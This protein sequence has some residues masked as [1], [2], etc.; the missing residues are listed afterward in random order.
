[1]F[2]SGS[3]SVR[4]FVETDISH[5]AFILILSGISW[6]NDVL[7]GHALTKNFVIFVATG[8]VERVLGMLASRETTGQAARLRS[9]ISSVTVVDDA[10]DI[11]LSALG[12]A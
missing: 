9:S 12:L 4:I 2:Q 6:V 1:M 11:L 3:F 10:L 7:D 5:L 8:D